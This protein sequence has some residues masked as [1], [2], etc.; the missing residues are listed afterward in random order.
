MINHAVEAAEHFQL[1]TLIGYRGT[2][3]PS[4]VLENDKIHV[5]YLSVWIVDLL[6]KLPKFLYL[7]YAFFRFLIQTLQLF[8]HLVCVRTPYNYLLIQNP[9][10]LPLLF[11]SV[12]VCFLSCGRT[13][14]IVDWHNYGF[15]ILEVGGSGKKLVKVA[16][17][18]E[19]FFGKMAWKHL[20]VSIAMKNDLVMLT[21]VNPDLVHVVYDRATS[22][23]KSLTKEEK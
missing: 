16:K 1:V 23:F 10:C 4:K 17:W 15:S 8:Y 20:T 14:L 12:M 11:V 21:G 19:V 2:S 5:S 9:P 3:M 13:R 6:R 22:K 18:Y 7:V